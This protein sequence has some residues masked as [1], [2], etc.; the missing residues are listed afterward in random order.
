LFFCTRYGNLPFFG[1]LALAYVVGGFLWAGL[2]AAHMDELI[3]LQYWITLVLG[4]GMLETL[5]R[6]HDFE[7]WNAHGVRDDGAM[8]FAVLCGTTKRA[9]SRVLVLIVS[10]GYGTTKPTLGETMGQ[11]LSL[12]ALYLGLATVQ[13]FY[14]NLSHSLPTGLLEFGLLFGLS[15]LDVAFIFWIFK[16]LLTTLHTLA[17]RRQLAKLALF[18]RLRD[19]LGFWCAVACVW[20]A[21]TMVLTSSRAELA[22]H[23][24]DAWW[25]DALWHVF[26][27]AVLSIV[28]FLWRPSTNALRYA[29]FAGEVTARERRDRGWG[30][31]DEGEYGGLP[32]GDDYDDDVVVEMTSAGAVLSAMD[33]DAEGGPAKTA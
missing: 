5:S 22:S 27:A 25:N 32:Q 12:G 1:W 20:A 23:W 21:Y 30:D 10:M 8:L 28:A 7:R 17:Q 13:E 11:V 24:Q 3:Q 15:L 31:D 18:R 4:L 2:M 9:L 16:S 29:S 14:F 6:Y 33:E 19:A 26:Y